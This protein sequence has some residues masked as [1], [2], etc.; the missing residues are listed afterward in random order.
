MLALVTSC[1]KSK[2]IAVGRNP[3]AKHAEQ[4]ARIQ[5][6]R[7]GSE[8]NVR[9]LTSRD[10]ESLEK[11][12]LSMDDGQRRQL[13]VEARDIRSAELRAIV[14]AKIYFT[15]K[16][17][18]DFLKTVETVKADLGPGKMG[19]EVLRQGIT[20]TD[21]PPDTAT[22]LF[23]S[24]NT[25][26]R[27]KLTNE[28]AGKLELVDLLSMP[29]TENLLEIDG[30]NSLL[31][32]AVE[33]RA[34]ALSESKEGRTKESI[35]ADLEEIRKSP[36]AIGGIEIYIAQ[37]SKILPFETLEVLLESKNPQLLADN[38]LIGE[39]TAQMAKQNAR[40]AI[41]VLQDK[42]LMTSELLGRTLWNW[43]ASDPIESLDWLRNNKQLSAAELDA[44]YSTVSDSNRTQK[45]YLSAWQAVGFIADPDLKRKAEGRVWSAERDSVLES[46]YSNPSGTMNSLVN[47][48]S[49]FSG[50]RLEG[51]MDAWMERDFETANKWYQENWNSM[52]ASK[53]QFLAASFAKQSLQQ[54]DTEAAREWATHITDPKTR[55]RIDTKIREFP[56]KQ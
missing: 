21:L 26:A 40:E 7:S 22:K 3:E 41:R 20:D 48:K 23:L 51:A 1:E 47:G 11:M 52:P 32:S 15:G 55:N 43:T 50:Y 5:R 49:D 53:S 2:E 8:I 36:G 25:E 9:N 17:G 12:L 14:M 35:A 29:N 16:S 24:L 31:A 46:V 13:L 10:M 56:E 37:I 19:I 33:V 34:K 6:A 39:L 54:G 4:K 42:G 45:N 27:R 30:M 44:G 18:N 38:D 28:I